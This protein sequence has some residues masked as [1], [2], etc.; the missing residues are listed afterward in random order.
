[1]AG[2]LRG[3]PKEFRVMLMALVSARTLRRS[4]MIVADSPLRLS[5]NRAKSSIQYL[6]REDLIISISTSSRTL[7]TSPRAADSWRKREK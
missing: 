3:V 5:T 1:M 6:M 7:E 4:P 2:S